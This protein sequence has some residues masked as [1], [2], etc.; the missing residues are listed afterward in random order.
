MTV[1]EDLETTGDSCMSCP[2]ELDA[3]DEVG[4]GGG[5]LFLSCGVVLVITVSFSLGETVGA[6]D[7]WRELGIESSSIG[8]RL[9]PTSDA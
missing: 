1:E 9:R 8:D 3:I 4:E 6:D 5:R 7:T 2:P